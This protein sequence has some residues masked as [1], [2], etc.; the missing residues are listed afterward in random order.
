MESIISKLTS[1]PPVLLLSFSVAGALY[2]SS[3][4][5]VF[6]VGIYNHFLRAGKNILKRYGS[7]A[8]VTGGKNSFLSLLYPI[9]LCSQPLMESE[10]LW[11]SSWL[12][13]AAAFF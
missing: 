9:S 8:V 12:A 5:Y 11:P 1:L 7:W 6:L 2:L 13:R 3:F 4:L 10:R